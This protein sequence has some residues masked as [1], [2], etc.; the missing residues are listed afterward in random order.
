MISWD[1]GKL[2]NGHRARNCGGYLLI[3]QKP[4][5]SRTGKRK[6]SAKNWTDHGI[7]DH[8]GRERRSQIHP[9]VKPFGLIRRLIGAVT[10]PGDLVIDPAAGTFVVMSAALE[11]KRTFVG[12]DLIVPES[13]TLLGSGCRPHRNFQ[14]TG[15]TTMT[16]DSRELNRLGDQVNL[17]RYAGAKETLEIVAERSLREAQND[18]DKAASSPAV[19]ARRR[20]TTR[21]IG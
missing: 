1:S 8:L 19:I 5:V 11:I 15:A 2:G 20:C 12:C 10:R 4:K 3:L 17:K 9:H 7:R 21:S 13:V 14:S 6:L 18:A 16:T